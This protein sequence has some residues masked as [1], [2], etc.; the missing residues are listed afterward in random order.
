MVEKTRMVAGRHNTE[1]IGP[2]VARLIMGK[3]IAGTFRARLFL[4][5]G[6]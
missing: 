2:R 3:Q 5:S 4:L 1:R 6:M